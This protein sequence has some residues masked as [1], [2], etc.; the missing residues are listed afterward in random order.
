M[1]NKLIKIKTHLDK[2]SSG[3]F[4]KLLSIVIGFTATVW[5]LIRVIPKPSRA[6]YPCQQ[7]AFPV[8]SGFVLWLVGLL[9]IK[10]SINKIKT[11]F[12]HKLWIGS[13]LVVMMIVSFLIWT[14]VS[15]S[16][17]IN[18]VPKESGT[19]YN[20]VPAK[21]NFPRGRELHPAINTN[22]EAIKNAYSPIVD[23]AASPNLG[24]KTILFVLDGLYCGRKWRT[25]P[26]HFPNPPF[27]NQV[28]PYENSDWPVSLLASLD[29]VAI[30]CVGLDIL[31]SQIKNNIDSSGHPRILLRNN[32]DDY[33]M[34]MALADNPPSGTKYIQDG[35]L[36]NSLGV[37]EHWD[38]NLTRKYSRNIN[39]SK[40]ERY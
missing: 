22:Q 36:V 21:S 7:A 38:G 30:D 29:G 25:Y 3:S 28:E 23:L 31:N 15:F 5:F 40:G 6:S 17:D 18:A 14:M 27:N 37:H 39:H 16:I 34:E 32:A 35:K 20:F 19:P 13:L 33:L 26:L 4:Y 8:A 9:T 10:P 11:A 24:A 1:N 12:P 2:I